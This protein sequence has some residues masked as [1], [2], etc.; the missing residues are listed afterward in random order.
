MLKYFS[1][2]WLKNMY[3][4]VYL[5][6]DFKNVWTTC[7]CKIRK[8][9]RQ[10]LLRLFSVC[11]SSECISE[12][13][14]W[15]VCWSYLSGRWTDADE[16]AAE[17]IASWNVRWTDGRRRRNR[18]NE[19]LENSRREFK[20][21]HPDSTRRRRLMTN[22][23]VLDYKIAVGH[24]D[25]SRNGPWTVSG[26][27]V[28]DRFG[29]A[30][31]F[32]VG[33]S[34]WGR[35]SLPLG[36]RRALSR[37]TRRSRGRL[38]VTS[39]PRRAPC[40]TTPPADKSH[41]PAVGVARRRGTLRVDGGPSS[42]PTVQSATSHRTLSTG[43]TCRLANVGKSRVPRA[44]L[45]VFCI[46]T[47]HCQLLVG[48]FTTPWYNVWVIFFLGMTCSNVVLSSRVG[49]AYLPVFWTWRI[50]AVVWP[51][52]PIYFVRNALVRDM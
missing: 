52:H 40:P 10:R 13:W 31:P 26:S 47:K 34:S 23:M 22:A 3:T 16:S 46:E 28:N 48:F 50:I 45:E 39:G 11:G 17:D 38:G 49:H 12:I 15:L 25:G 7:V 41:P 51:V 32:I 18:F 21:N 35:A 8:R 9:T 29:N 37:R 36:R 30:Q 24:W 1:Q 44:D 4:P 33:A 14:P 42:M 43:L 5:L 19:P 2:R 27:T 6:I 20:K